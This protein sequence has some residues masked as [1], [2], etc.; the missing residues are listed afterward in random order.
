MSY[1]TLNIEQIQFKQKTLREGVFDAL[2]F[3][4]VQNLTDFDLK[5]EFFSNPRPGRH[6]ARHIYRVM[7]ASAL[8]ALRMNEPRRGLLA[9][10]GAFIHDLAQER[11]GEGKW[12]GP[13][14]A[15]EKWDMF[16][17]IWD[18]YNLSEDERSKV[19]AAVSHH[20]GGGNSGF[21]DDEIVNQILHDADSLDR[22][23]FR[24]HGR[25]NWSDL[26]LPLLTW[27]DGKP[28]QELKYLIGETEAICGYTKHLNSFLPFKEFI[29]YIR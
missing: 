17:S 1:S 9:F 7:L 3:I 29:S 10:C 4:G 8:I 24:Q 5:R 26:S 28:S 15:K 18:R 27:S 16:N 19:R 22:C 6:D 25:M 20:S 11:D 2:S 14:A 13:K 21:I 12:H 23:R